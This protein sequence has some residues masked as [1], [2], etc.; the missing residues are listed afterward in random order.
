MIQQESSGA[1]KKKKNGQQCQNSTGEDVS[2]IF[3]IT[4][5]DMVTMYKS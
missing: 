1:L 4:T 2:L 3:N 5:D